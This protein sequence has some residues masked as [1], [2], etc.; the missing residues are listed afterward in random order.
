M[1]HACDRPR[2]HALFVGGLLLLTEER[3]GVVLVLLGTS[4]APC[5]VVLLGFDLFEHGV[6]A[7]RFDTDV[8][9]PIEYGII[10]LTIDILQDLVHL[11]VMRSVHLD[12]HLRMRN[13]T[14]AHEGN[15][16]GRRVERRVG[17]E[18][19][20]EQTVGVSVHGASPVGGVA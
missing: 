5:L 10:V 12:T 19:G 18:V 16:L 13:F 15:V 1:S 11:S 14:W 9:E 20:R 2:N 6:V 3:I 7:I 4:K 8:T 17:L